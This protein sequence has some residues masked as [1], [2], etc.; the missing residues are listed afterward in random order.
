[1]ILDER[2]GF[3]LQT[4]DESGS[5]SSPTECHSERNEVKSKNL[6]PLLCDKIFEKLFE[7]Y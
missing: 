5:T 4:K 2:T 6:R 7:F 1:M 3:A